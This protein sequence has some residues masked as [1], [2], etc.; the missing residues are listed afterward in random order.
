LTVPSPEVSPHRSVG[1]GLIVSYVHEPLTL[2]NPDGDEI[3]G[4]G[5]QVT[6][7]FLWSFGLWDRLQLGLALPVV[8]SQDGEG[9]APIA[10]PDPADC[11]VPALAATAIRDIRLDAKL[12]L[13]KTGVARALGAGISVSLPTGD[14]QNFAGTDGVSVLPML[15]L[16][17][18]RPTPRLRLGAAIGGRLRGETEVAD[19]KFG[20]ELWARVGAGYEVVPRL[21]ISAEYFGSL[22]LVDGADERMEVIGAVRFSPDRAEDVTLELGGG[23]GL[24]ESAGSPAFRAIAGVSYAP[25]GR[26]TDS[27]GV[28]DRTDACLTRREDRDGFEDADGCPDPDNDGDGVADGRDG[29][30]D[31]AEDADG[32]ADADGCPEPDNDEDGVADADDRCPTEAEDQD[33]FE[34][35]DGCKD[36]D[37]DGDGVPDV[38]DACTTDPEDQDGFEDE[39]G[40]PDPDN[41]GDGKLDAQDRC[42]NEAE[43]RDGFEDD[44]GCPDPDDDQDGVLDAS[45]RCNGEAETINGRDDDDGCPDPGVAAFS[46]QGDVLQARRGPRF[47]AGAST[48]PPRS[49]SI[50][51]Q[52]AQHVRARVGARFVVLGFGDRPVEDDAMRTLARAR[53]EVIKAAL[54]AG[55]VPAAWIDAEVGPLATRRGAAPQ[56]EV[57]AVPAPAPAPAAPAPAARAPAP[58]P[59]Q[60]GTP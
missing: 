41:D 43:D 18:L 57:R 19:A 44:D 29:C 30:D 36:E 2:L 31:E 14:D 39:N 52:L 59:A 20:S 53:A 51:A 23:A 33:E 15:M 40:C 35:E 1:F 16:G 48:L 9:I 34:D 10:C 56:W 7:D 11:E 49:E 5:H 32:F 42:P 8:V 45:D 55:G 37:D 50:V 46:W 3:L 4:V 47:A 54:V 26:D 22:P 25:L 58:A 12:R 28:L 27:D 60:G 24:S 17:G 6:A 38:R 21:A 13:G